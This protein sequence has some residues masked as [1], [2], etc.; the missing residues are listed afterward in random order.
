M[1]AQY[2]RSEGDILMTV[3]TSAL[4]INDCYK[5]GILSTKY[6]GNIDISNGCLIVDNSS[7]VYD[8]VL[9]KKGLCPIRYRRNPAKCA[10]EWAM[11]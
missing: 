2:T 11:G 5:T 8:F 10:F 9:K 3:E 7:I 1:Y 6:A 4:A